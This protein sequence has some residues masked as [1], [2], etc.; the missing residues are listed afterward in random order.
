MCAPSLGPRSA[1]VER[2]VAAFGEQQWAAVAAGVPGRSAGD[3]RVAW[4]RS[5]AAARGPWT[6]EEDSTIRQAAEAGKNV[7]HGFPRAESL[8]HRSIIRFIPAWS[9]ALK[10]CMHA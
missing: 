1:E 6:Q 3:C 5:L 9:A 4:R 7:R 10:H 8:S 2:R